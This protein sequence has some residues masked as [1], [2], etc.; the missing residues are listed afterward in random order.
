MREIDEYDDK[1]YGLAFRLAP[2]VDRFL[3]R[4]E[5]TLDAL[6]GEL[7]LVNI[8]DDAYADLKR[9]AV[10]MKTARMERLAEARDDR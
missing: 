5:R 1:V 2:A 6:F 4:H 10:E 3:A 9:V 8:E 7:G